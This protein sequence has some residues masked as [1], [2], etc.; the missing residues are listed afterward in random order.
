MEIQFQPIV[1]L[2]AEACR[3]K[4][5]LRAAKADGIRYNREEAL[6]DV[7]VEIETPCG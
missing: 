3:L 2:P 5:R 4:L 6:P 1:R 7:G